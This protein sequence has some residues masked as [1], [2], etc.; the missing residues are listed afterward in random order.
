MSNRSYGRLKDG[1][2]LTDEVADKLAEEFE[3]EDVDLSKWHRVGR[4][5]LAG[6]DGR[7]PR[8]NLR[9]TNELHARAIARAEQEGKTVSEVAREA[10]ERYVG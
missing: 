8:I 3:H 7:S 6:G 5:S 4:K 2:E 10:L 1:T 9:L